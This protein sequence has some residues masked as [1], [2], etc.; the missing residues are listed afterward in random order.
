MVS[1]N[2][3]GHDI[4]EFDAIQVGLIHLAASEKQ[5]SGFATKCPVAKKEKRPT[6]LSGRLAL[7]RSY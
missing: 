3:R 6:A 5:P 4:L 1:R 7:L 2:R